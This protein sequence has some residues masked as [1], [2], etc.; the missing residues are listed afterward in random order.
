MNISIVVKTSLLFSQIIDERYEWKLKSEVTKFYLTRIANI[1]SDQL[2][3]ISSEMKNPLILQIS[4]Y[5]SCEIHENRISV[6]GADSNIFFFFNFL[7][8][9]LNYVFI[10]LQT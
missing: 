3:Q 9:F 2:Q 6:D 5:F 10:R 4:S 7:F 1:K 8:S